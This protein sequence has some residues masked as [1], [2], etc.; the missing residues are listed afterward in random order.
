MLGM[1]S[2]GNLAKLMKGAQ[3]VQRKFAE[4]QERLA[5]ETVEGSAGGDMVRVTANGRREIIRIE[6]DPSLMSAED[7]EMLQELIVAAVNQALS[8][9]RARAQQETEK[10]LGEYGLPPGMLNLSD[11]RG[12]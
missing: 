10:L 1:E 11:M 7:R 6:M 8:R 5:K 12:G 2:L 3:E 4:L 9:A